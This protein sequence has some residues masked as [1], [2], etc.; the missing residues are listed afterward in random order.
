MLQ[1]VICDH[2]LVRNR[3]D[4][5]TQIHLIASSL[6]VYSFLL[7]FSYS[8]ARVQ[9][10][11]E[12]ILVQSFL[13]PTASAHDHALTLCLYYY[14]LTLENAFLDNECNPQTRPVCLQVTAYCFIPTVFR[15][16]SLPGTVV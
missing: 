10:V 4:F 8:E 11:F 14:L 7:P 13:F 16:T 15:S 2:K 5:L 6:I 1:Y 3:I 12:D 9:G